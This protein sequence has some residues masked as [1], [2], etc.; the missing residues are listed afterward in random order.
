M[1]EDLAVIKFRV[2][3]KG[4]TEKFSTKTQGDALK[5][6]PGGVPG[7]VEALIQLG[8]DAIEEV[9]RA[10]FRDSTRQMKHVKFIRDIR[11][12]VI[13]R[14]VRQGQST[15]TLLNATEFASLDGIVDQIAEKGVAS[16]G[17]S[18]RAEIISATESLIEDTK[19]ADVD[20][21]TRKA[22]LIKLHSFQRVVQ[23][24]DLYSDSQLRSRIKSIVADFAAEF[25]TM[26]KRHRPFF[27]RVVQ[28]GR[29]SLRASGGAIGLIADG[30]TVAGLLGPPQ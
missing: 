6:V 7:I 24:A 14:L 15:T 30:T 12:R 13:D 20:D 25:A 4:L 1:A 8:D 16:S 2:L 18:N 5:T 19:K 17:I 21:Y 3:L 11:N 22:L 28:W 9:E 27:E 23:A 26:D 29:S 10:E